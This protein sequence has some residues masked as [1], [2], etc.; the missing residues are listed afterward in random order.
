MEKVMTTK[1]GTTLWYN[2]STKQYQTDNWND[3]ENA[4]NEDIN[5]TDEHAAQLATDILSDIIMRERAQD[6]C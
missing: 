2:S 4:L 1:N 5:G 6:I 3:V